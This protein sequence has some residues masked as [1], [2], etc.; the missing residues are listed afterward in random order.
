MN[1]IIVIVIVIVKKGVQIYNQISL[2][3]CSK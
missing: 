1:K 2:E 3:T